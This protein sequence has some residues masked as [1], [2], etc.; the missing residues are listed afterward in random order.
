MDASVPEMKTERD[1]L[2]SGCAVLGGGLAGL[3]A[4]YT[5]ARSGMDVQVFE[6]APEVGGLSRTVVCGEF[7]YDIGGHRFFTRDEE[8]DSIVRSLMGDELISV[9]RTSKIFMRERFFDYP[10]KPLNA[11]FGL[12]LPMVMKIIL[13]YAWH[14]LK[15]RALNGSARCVSL[16]DWVVANFGRTMFEIYFREYSEKVWG[17]DCT[18]I[19]E[20]WVS[21]RI[22]GLSLGKAVRNAFFR[23]SGRDIPTLADTF[24]YPALG[25]GRISER[26]EE[27]INSSNRVHRNTSAAGIRHDGR[28][29]NCLMLNNCDSSFEFRGDHYIS[30]IP[31]NTLVEIMDP[32]PPPQVLEAARSLGFRDLVT[33]SLAVNKPTVTDQSWIYIP[34]SRFPFGRLHEPKIWSSSM[35]PKDRTLVVVEYFCFRGDDI[36]N[37]PDEELTRM[38]TLGLEE[39]GFI[40]S[41]DVLG[42]DI[43]RVPRA[44][45]LFEVGF[46]RHCKVIMDYLE[47]FDNL[48]VAGRSGMF[49]YQ[50][51]DHAIR[52]GMEAAGEA[53][54]KAGMA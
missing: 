1:S 43:L 44:Y 38:T 41:G 14:R 3:S 5:L 48:S 53:V 21:R 22:Q 7:R 42:S 6:A 11:M 36:W 50:N 18:R 49:E 16:E 28:R 40:T 2:K 12:G 27:E 35:A 51:M 9:D 54:K 25:I 46:D 45:P 32:P 34:E 17:L 26:Y 29:V 20:S 33:V 30:T 15:A 10:L 8:V 24:L 4:G 39:L 52:S 19:C 47:G 31:L 23:F 37:T 13:D